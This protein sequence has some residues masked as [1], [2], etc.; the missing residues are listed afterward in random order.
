MV[1]AAFLGFLVL[2][3]GRGG[4]NRF[5]QRLLT[6]PGRWTFLGAGIVR[7][8]LDWTI[9]QRQFRCVRSF[10]RPDYPRL[11]GG[12]VAGYHGDPRGLLC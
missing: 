11:R 7:L 1:E 5:W 4:G 12:W 10:W 3:L 8:V 6:D 2:E 9:L